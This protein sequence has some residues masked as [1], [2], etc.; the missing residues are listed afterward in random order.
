MKVL[1]ASIL[2]ASL[3]ATA[4][5]QTA[6]K[7]ANPKKPVAVSKAPAPTKRQAI[8]EATPVSEP[9]P[10]IK[11]SEAQL[12]I[13]K[14]VYVGEIQCAELIP[15]R[16]DDQRVGAICSFFRRSCECDAGQQRLGL[17]ASHWIECRDNCTVGQQ[18]L[19]QRNGRRI[20]HV[21]CIW[22]EG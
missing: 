4:Q 16:D 2:I 12:A 13:A 18:A 3:A 11:L 7:P 21:I 22:L 15:L 17:L 10:R 1:F 19:D 20:A 5:A 9:D 8:E 14:T 6:E